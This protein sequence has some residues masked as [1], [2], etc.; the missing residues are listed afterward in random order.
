MKTR[1]FA[2]S[3]AL[4][5]AATLWAGE[6]IRIFAIGNSFS[7]DAVEQNLH[8]ICSAAGVDVVIGNMYIGGCSI[9][10]H[11][12]SIKENIP[13][14]SYRKIGLDGILTQKD[15]VTLPDCIGDE[16]WDIITVQ[17]C[18]PDSGF[19]ETYENLDF[20]LK[21]VKGRCP[22]AKLM[23]HQTWA[24]AEDSTHPDFPRYGCDQKR[25]YEAIMSASSRAV[26]EYRLIVIPCGTAI[27]NA[28]GTFLKASGD[29]L[30]RDGFHLDYRLGRY[31]AAAT[32]FE[33]LTQKS[34][35]RNSYC[36]EG[37]SEKELL[38]AQK[39]AH[40]AALRPFKLSKM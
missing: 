35:V 32:W 4:L 22:K 6:P 40:K 28:R 26:E 3:A 37:V 33:I 23:F 34:V 29:E 31:I 20:L 2:F 9:D 39:C 18:S 25:M 1:L 16:P 19:W 14:Y 10:R 11:T 27:Q 21:W 17:Q 30:T 8:E 38:M 12:E 36:P 24:Y 5:F 13:D 7:V 15:G